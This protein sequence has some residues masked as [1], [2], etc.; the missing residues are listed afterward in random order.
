MQFIP[1]MIIALILIW[2]WESARWLVVLAVLSIV[3]FVAYAIV[4]GLRTRKA[5]EALQLEAQRQAEDA[6]RQFATKSAAVR[7]EALAR[8]NVHRK[9][10]RRKADQSIFKNDYGAYVF[11]KWFAERDYFINNVLA[12]ECPGLKTYVDEDWLTSTVGA[13]ALSAPDESDLV[14]SSLPE[15]MLPIEFEHYCAELLRHLGWEAHVTPATGDQGVDILAEYRGIRAVFQCKLYASTV[16]NSAVQEIVAGRQ[17]QRAQ[18][19]GVISNSS[20][21]PSAR[22]LAAAADVHLLHFTELETLS[23]QLG[24]SFPAEYVDASESEPQLRGGTKDDRYTDLVAPWEEVWGQAKAAHYGFDREFKDLSRARKLYHT[25]AK[26]GCKLAFYRIG[27]LDFNAAEDRRA[28]LNVVNICRQGAS[29]QNYACYLLLAK[30]YLELEE[31]DNA[32]K[33]LANFFD[34]RNRQL[35]VK[36]EVEL[37]VVNALAHILGQSANWVE[38]LDASALLQLKLLRGELVATFDEL[39]SEFN[40]DGE[41]WEVVQG[42]EEARSQLAAL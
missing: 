42:Y 1:F 15:G 32:G 40:K 22:Q 4:E 41:S 31:H 10:L 25:A 26:L 6:Q 17:F 16:G 14:P 20:F 12:R 5:N 27:M 30:I 38:G 24:V 21:T 33:A 37:L 18:V 8:I 35:D 28:M 29:S 7:S 34:N 19:A 2:V 23:V 11:D 9:V 39:I 36:L 13:I 3:G